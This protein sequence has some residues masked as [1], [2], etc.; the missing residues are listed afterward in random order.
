VIG[1]ASIVAGEDLG[2]ELP[3]GRSLF[4]GV[5][6]T[7]SGAETVFIVG[8]SGIGKT[9][10]LALV[11]RLLRPTSGHVQWAAGMRARDVAWVLQTT[12]NLAGRGVLANLQLM[13]RLDAMTQDDL[14]DRTNNLIDQLD[15]RGLLSSKAS[16]LSGGE[17]QRVAIARA[18]I[19]RRPLILADEPTSQVDRDMAVRIMTLLGGSGTLGRAAVV[20]T[21][22]LAAIPSGHRVL[23]LHG[24]GLEL[25]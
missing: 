8:P 25:A 20:V 18:L 22:D 14:T 2:Y 9:T 19:S 3:S 15:L 17:M 11:G 6:L 4:A 5:D 21:H 12:T 16:A 13:G 1:E 23:R 24:D 7:V 10:L